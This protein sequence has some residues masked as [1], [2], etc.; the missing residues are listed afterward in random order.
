MGLENTNTIAI[1]KQTKH[2]AAYLRLG[3]PGRGDHFRFGSV[4]TYKNQPNRLYI[5][6]LKKPNRL[7]IFL[8]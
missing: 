1:I 8:T 7:Y 5:F 6:F 2:Q 4:F 3:V